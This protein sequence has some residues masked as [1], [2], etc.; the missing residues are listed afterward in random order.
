MTPG[1]EGGMSLSCCLTANVNQFK[2]THFPT[3][4]V[5][6][7]DSSSHVIRKKQ[8]FVFKGEGWPDFNIYL[9]PTN[10]MKRLAVC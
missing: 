4:T 7:F 8:P 2:Q 6:L 9:L 10:A 5:E 1:G 3:C